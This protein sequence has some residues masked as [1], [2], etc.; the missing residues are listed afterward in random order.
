MLLPCAAAILLVAS[1]QTPVPDRGQAEALARS[2]QTAEALALFERIVAA[3]PADADAR[4]WIARL[5]MRLGDLGRAEREYRV[6][7][8]DHPQDV[9]ALMGLGM[10][11]TRRGAPE[12]ALQLLKAA[13]RRSGDYGD[14]FAALARAYR[15]AGDDGAAVAYFTKARAL[16]GND[17]D[18]DLGYDAAQRVFGHW[19]AFDGVYQTGASELVSGTLDADLRVAPLLHIQGSVR[20]QDSTDYTDTIGGAGLLWRMQPR[21]TL[22][23]RGLG[24]PDNIA[25]ATRDL[26]AELM[27]YSGAYEIGASLRGIRFADAQVV[28]SSALV[29]WNA[30][31]AWR[32]ATRYTFSRSTF[33]ETGEASGDHSA[34][35]NQVWQAWRRVAV[36]GTYAYGIEAFEDLTAD[37][38][39]SLGTNTVAFGLRFDLRSL[40]R[41]TASVEHQWRSNHTT[42]MR[43]GISLVQLVP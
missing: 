21:T 33:D 38:L 16:P 12:A 2:G 4:Q 28:A 23:L 18:V 39:G 19:I 32:L 36:S 1:L 42:V 37:R 3:N 31:D 5:A 34:M 13:E 35:V 9:D 7:L 20:V 14:L 25:L 15:R 41:I 26:S 6:V 29:A 43:Y 11:L 30:N 24:G 22:S 40:T 27:H 10:V 8:R 17:P